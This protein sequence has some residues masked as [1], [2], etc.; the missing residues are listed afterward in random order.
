MPLN[1]GDLKDLS[2]KNSPMKTDWQ[3]FRVP[4]SDFPEI[5]VNTHK[6]GINDAHCA[7]FLK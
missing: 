1:R 5:S 3:T 6:D 2:S 7:Q 4:I